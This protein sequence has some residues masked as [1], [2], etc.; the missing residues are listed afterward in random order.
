MSGICFAN[1]EIIW[2]EQFNRKAGNRELAEKI[3]R[4]IHYFQAPPF[5]C[6]I[7]RPNT[8]RSLMTDV[9]AYPIFC[10]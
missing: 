8:A 3:L 10:G 9:A 4:K 7:D 5:Y 6:L 1:Y 2:L